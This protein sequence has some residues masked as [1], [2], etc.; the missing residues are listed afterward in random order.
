MDAA[1]L[2]R[3]GLTLGL[4]LAMPA[5]LLWLV[6]RFGLKL[7]G[8][9]A[10]AARLGIVAR[11]AIDARHSLVL[12]KRDAREQLLL[13]GPNG[14]MILEL[15]IELSAEDQAEQRR[16]AD[17]EQARVAAAQAAMAQARDRA[18]LAG[19]W[20]RSRL[21]SLIERARQV[22]APSFAR[23]VERARPPAPVKMGRAKTS[24]GRTGA[25]GRSTRQVRSA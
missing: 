12:I 23:L 4:L 22:G 10:G 16:I 19:D 6:R 13:L 2:M 25:S 1:S 3:M 9:Y 14:P 24:M 15:S 17:E 18:R 21:A 8:H 20:A 11:T 5:G 7:R